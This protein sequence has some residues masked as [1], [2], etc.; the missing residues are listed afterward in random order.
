MN[1]TLAQHT[2]LV[3]ITDENGHEYLDGKPN[4]FDFTNAKILSEVNT[5]ISEIVLFCQMSKN[6]SYNLSYVNIHVKIDSELE[7][8][9][10]LF[11]DRG[12]V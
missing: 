7:A 6:E 4:T 5:A 8:D 11:L 3:S 12:D 2:V 10:M 9:T 1:F